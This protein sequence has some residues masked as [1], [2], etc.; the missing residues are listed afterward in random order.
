MFGLV[1]VSDLLSVCLSV[2]LS[3]C[4]LIPQRML[5]LLV[6]VEGEVVV[7]ALLFVL[8]NGWGAEVWS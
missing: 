8:S 4:L 2:Y 5:L 1:S 7:V 3:V 6:V